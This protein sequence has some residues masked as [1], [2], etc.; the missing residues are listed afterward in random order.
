MKKN[1]LAIAL[2]AMVPFSFAMAGEGKHF[3][4]DHHKKMQ[5]KFAQELNLTTEQQSQIKEIKA[6]HREARKSEMEE[7]K[8]VL[9]PEQQAKMDEMRAKMKEKHKERMKKHKDNSEIASE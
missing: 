4:G 6:K 8:S 3:D 9:T 1:I 2:A 5:D 7:I